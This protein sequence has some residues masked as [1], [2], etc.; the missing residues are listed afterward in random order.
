LGDAVA[1]GEL[2]QDAPIG[3]LVRM[4]RI[5]LLS[6]GPVTQDSGSF[7]EVEDLLRGMSKLVRTAWGTGAAPN[8]I[9]KAARRSGY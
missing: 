8:G 5:T 9:D 2:R 7:A 3:E 1:A 4:L 6:C